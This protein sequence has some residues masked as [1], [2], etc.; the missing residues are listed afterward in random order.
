MGGFIA[1]PGGVVDPEVDGEDHHA[2]GRAAHRELWEETGLVAEED[3]LTYRSEPPD[4]PFPGSTIARFTTPTWYPIRF[5]TWFFHHVVEET[6]AAAQTDEDMEDI[7]F[8]SPAAL[9]QRWRELD[10]L[11]APPTRRVLEALASLDD[12]RDSGT[13]A[14]SLVDDDPRLAEEFEP[15]CGIHALPL[16]TPTLPPA[17]HTN[18]YL[19]GHERLLVVDPATYDDGE[20]ER[21][22]AV[23][24]RLGR[25]VEAVF[26]THHHE[27]H[28]GSA[29]WLSQRLDV[30]V[31][32]HPA[33]ADLVAEQVRVDRTFE[34][35]DVIGLGP[36]AAGTPYE[37]ELMHT[38]GHAAG[39]LVLIDRRRAERRSLIVGDMVAS[40]GTII[41][42]PDDGSMREYVS[43]LQRM[44]DLEPGVL[45]PSHGPPIFDGVA[46][47]D[48]YIAHRAMREEKVF[49][50]VKEHGPSNARALVP[51]AY[52]DTPERAWPLAERSLLAHLEKLVED[53]RVNR[54]G[55]LYAALPD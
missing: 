19:L 9:L 48:A 14:E 27:D 41:V 49:S 38:P 32:A 28:V 21:L 42:D 3:R 39:H 11:I 8:E 33:T 45:F 50:A 43:Q 51:F 55:V 2:L 40:V 37:L 44:R 26:L 6:D 15:M 7:R 25:P 35:G 47:L 18:C 12:P 31:W 23:L 34:D 5:E 1:F 4:A 24:E 20:R 30:P 16:R 46:K 13:L 10:Y 22:A 52:D 29:R 53:G 17:T 36:D 54:D